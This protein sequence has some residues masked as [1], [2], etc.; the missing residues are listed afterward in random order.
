[1]AKYGTGKKYGTG[2]KYGF[3]A[4]APPEPPSWSA[5]EG[6]NHAGA[7][8]LITSDITVAGNHFNIGRL[9]V[10]SG[11][12]VTVESYDGSQYGHWEAQTRSAEIYGSIVGGG[13]GFR[14]GAVQAIGEGPFGGGLGQDGGYR[15]SQGQGDASTDETTVRG[16]GGGGS[17][18]AGEGAGGD[19]GAEIRIFA[20]SILRLGASGKITV[21]GAIGGTNAG[22][23][24]GGGVLLKCDGPYGERIEGTI[25]SLGGVVDVAI[26][27][28]V[29]RFT[30]PGLLTGGGSVTAGRDFTDATLQKAGI[31]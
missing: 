15:T 8:W 1:M 12:V 20:T 31:A 22:D 3:D 7:D 13:H 4:A 11:V 24:A 9:I 30:L 16:S 6:G 26:G 25:E 27:G 21:H 28:T 5:L 18:A 14:G 29:K 23:G 17:A 10:S 2:E 19:G